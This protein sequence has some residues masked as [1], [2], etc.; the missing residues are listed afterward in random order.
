MKDL[1]GLRFGRLVVQWPVGRQGHLLTWLCLCDC[2]NLKTVIG[3]NLPRTSSCRCIN[4]EKA[5]ASE[6]ERL[7]RRLN[8]KRASG[9]CLTCSVVL[10]T[11]NANPSRVKSGSGHC[12]E[13][14]G[15]LRDEEHQKAKIDR[16]NLRV[17]VFDKLGHKCSRCGFDDKRALQVDHINGGGE[18][19]RQRFSQTT[20]LKHVLANPHLFQI[21]C[22]NCNWI[23]RHENEEI[24]TKKN[25]YKHFSVHKK[26]DRRKLK[27]LSAVTE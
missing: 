20:F 14:R 17:E 3:S 23:K 9:K 11:E 24:F 2:G 6:Q 1:S 7:V 25:S 4:K 8:K 27:E 13:C 19:D 22:A 12:N 26:T 5:A 15:G 18:K 16:D 10:T 21:L